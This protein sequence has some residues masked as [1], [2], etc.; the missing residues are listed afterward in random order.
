[1]GTQR[2]DPTHVAVV[3]GA[4]RGIGLGIATQ[5]ARQGLTVALLDRDGGALDEAVGALAAEGLNAFGAT[6]DLTDSAAV[7]DAFA[8]VSARAGRVDYLVNNAGAVRDMR[9]LKMT[10]DDWDLVIDTNLR[11]QFLCCRAA[12]PG[13]VERGYGRVVNISSRAWLGGF[14][15]A[16]YS[17]AKGGV[18][19]LTRSLAIEFASKGITVNAVAPGIVDTPLFRGFAPEVQARLQTSV[20]VQRIGTADDIANAVSF[21]LDP[22]SSY[23]TGQTLYVCGGRSL[24]SPS[25]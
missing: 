23:V 8:Q 2:F 10:D 21:F 7:N 5:L 1:M 18:V 16:N 15:Q 6:A 13:M 22:Q 20:P 24:S 12:L 19:S 9:F 4:A 14:G 25:V 17:A 11:S 3:T